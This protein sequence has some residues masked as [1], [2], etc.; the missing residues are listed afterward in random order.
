LRQVLSL[1]KEIGRR[2]RVKIR[3]LANGTTF[4]FYHSV[5]KIPAVQGAVC[6][7]WLALVGAGFGVLLDYQNA[8]GSIGCTPSAWPLG[9]AVALDPKRDTLIMFAHPQCSC[10]EASVEELNRLL[11]V[12]HDRV[13][14]QIWFF[15]PAG[16]PPDWTHSGLCRS[17]AAIPGVTIQ[18]DPDGRQARRF[19]A[20]TSG[21]VVLYDPNGKLL[22]DGGITGSRGHAGDNAGANAV[23]SLLAG[24]QPGLRQTP[25]Y[26]CSLLGECKAAQNSMPP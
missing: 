5:S 24:R 4:A 12:F 17:A 15:Q 9:T 6:L 20:A 1:P 16:S 13:A 18:A 25:V 21:F 26:G 2:L 3:H 10:T 19:G 22:F 14:A 7:A 8:S 23:A 11:A